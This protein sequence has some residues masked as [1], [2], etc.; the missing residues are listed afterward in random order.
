MYNQIF[1]YIMML[2]LKVLQ[3]ITLS[4]PDKRNG[5]SVDQEEFHHL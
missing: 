5:L 2:F 1:Y 3:S 4:Q